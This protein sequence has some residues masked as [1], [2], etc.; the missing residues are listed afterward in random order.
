MGSSFVCQLFPE[1]YV[2]VPITDEM[3]G[4]YFDPYFSFLKKFLENSSS[5]VGPVSCY[6]I[7]RKM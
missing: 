3:V 2:V 1:Q 6:S 5:G 4:L 7:G